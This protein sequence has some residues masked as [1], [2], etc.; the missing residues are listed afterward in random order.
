M[1]IK[2]CCWFVV[3]SALLS[4]CATGKST[5]RTFRNTDDSALIVESFDTRSS[6]N[7]SPTDKNDTAIARALNVARNLAQH[8]TAIVILEDYSEPEIGLQFRDRATV[9]FVGLRGV[10]YQHIV[11]LKGHG[12][13]DPDGLPVVA[14]YF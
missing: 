5:P 12:V 7:T 4:S 1:K 9:W 3:L 11:F 8:R 6:Q 13:A 10:G 2:I 14:E